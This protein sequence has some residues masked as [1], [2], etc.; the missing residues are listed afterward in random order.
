M[1]K[2]NT[3]LNFYAF[4]YFNVMGDNNNNG[5]CLD[6]QGDNVVVLLELGDNVVVVVFD[7]KTKSNN[8]NWYEIGYEL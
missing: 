5:L 8:N 7:G 2:P 1:F 6:F 3:R 4:F